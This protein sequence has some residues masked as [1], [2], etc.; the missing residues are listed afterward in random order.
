MAHAEDLPG[1][2]RR[3]AV[4]A[5]EP[6]GLPGQRRPVGGPLLQQA[7]LLRD[8]HPVG[9]LPLRPIELAGRVGK[10]NT[11]CEGEDNRSKTPG[12]LFTSILLNNKSQADAC[13][14]AGKARSLL[15]L[16]ARGKGRGPR[17]GCVQWHS[18]T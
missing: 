11:Q 6:L 9:P 17:S 18:Q 7:R 2:D 13:E 15:G 5:P 4:A 12:E 10:G 3:P 8:A 1:G 14:Q 16:R